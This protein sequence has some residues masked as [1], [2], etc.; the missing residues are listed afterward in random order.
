MCDVQRDETSTMRSKGYEMCSFGD[1]VVS[2]C[3]EN[4]DENNNENHNK[5][6]DEIDNDDTTSNNKNSADRCWSKHDADA[7]KTTSNHGL[8]VRTTEPTQTQILI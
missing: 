3:E 8:N 6:H 2:C 5:N 7:A 1:G 4:D